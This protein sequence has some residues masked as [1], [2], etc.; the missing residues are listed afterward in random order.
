MRPG[1]TYRINGHPLRVLGLADVGMKQDSY[2]YCYN[3]D[4]D[5]QFDIVLG[6]SITAAERVRAVVIPA[7]GHGYQAFYNPGGPGTT[8]VAGIHY[9]T[10]GPRHRQKVV[11][12]PHDPITVTYVKR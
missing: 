4:H 6:G 12:A 9:T 10:P 3:D 7:V 2:D 11:N 8:P 1:R 5:N